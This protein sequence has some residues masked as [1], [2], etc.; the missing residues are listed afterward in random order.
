MFRIPLPGEYSRL[1]AGVYKAK[2]EDRRPKTEDRRPKTEDR[3]PKIEDQKTKTSLK[4]IVRRQSE[5]HRVN[6]LLRAKKH[7]IDRVFVL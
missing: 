2:T 7:E 6:A 1:S 4:K 5:D 3:R